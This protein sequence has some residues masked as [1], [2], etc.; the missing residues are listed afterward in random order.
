MQAMCERAK[1]SMSGQSQVVPVLKTA[2]ISVLVAE[3]AQLGQL[4]F[5]GCTLLLLSV[6]DVSVTILLEPQDS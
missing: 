6:K 5:H 2:C 3:H 4:D 1:T